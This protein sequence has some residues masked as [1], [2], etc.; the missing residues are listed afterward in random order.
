MKGRRRACPASDLFVVVVITTETINTSPIP[1][2]GP[3]CSS[4]VQ[5][6][7]VNRIPKQQK[8]Q[9]GRQA[10]ITD[11]WLGES[12]FSAVSQQNNLS[13]LNI[14]YVPYFFPSFH[15]FRSS[16]R[17]IRT[18]NVKHD[19]KIPSIMSFSVPSSI[20]MYPN[21]TLG[22][23]CLLKRLFRFHVQKTVILRFMDHSTSVTQNFI[24]FLNSA[25][26]QANKPA[27]P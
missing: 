26:A 3:V 10:P 21:A 25:R 24:L 2:C 7:T 17:Q 9:E 15:S 6:M 16:S 11:L 27:E 18:Q 22:N 4:A 8:M 20:W 12:K 19:V 5:S 1:P 23:N 14:H 13:S